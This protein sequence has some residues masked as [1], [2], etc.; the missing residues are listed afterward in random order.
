MCFPHTKVFYLIDLNIITIDNSGFIIY[1]PLKKRIKTL[2]KSI[3]QWININKFNCKIVFSSS[4]TPGE[5]EHKLLQYLKQLNLSNTA[6]TVIYGLDADLLFL[7]L[8]SKKD[9]LYLMRETS[10]MELNNYGSSNDVDGFSYLS[11]KILKDVINDEMIQRCK[12]QNET[13]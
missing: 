5:G 9:N 8:S 1:K 13:H 12:P 7:A 11:I 2:N 3:L 6:N 4:Y 10:Q